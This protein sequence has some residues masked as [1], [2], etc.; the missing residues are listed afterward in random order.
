M[1]ELTALVA[2]SSASVEERDAMH[3]IAFVKATLS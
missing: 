3:A 2:S 1:E